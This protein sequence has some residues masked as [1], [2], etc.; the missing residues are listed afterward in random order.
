MIKE[1]FFFL[2]FT[3]NRY[4]SAPIGRIGTKEIWAS[5]A[6]CALSNDTDPVN[7]DAI[8]KIFFPLF[9]LNRYNSVPLGHIWTKNI[10]AFTAR[11]YLSD[12]PGTVP[13]DVIVS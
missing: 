2:L 3:L 9:T 1:K 7:L 8:V 5:R 6:R 4:N 13:L 10:C 12:D 11:R